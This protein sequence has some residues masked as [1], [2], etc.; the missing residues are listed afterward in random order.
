M[1]IREFVTR[2]YAGYDLWNS[3]SSEEYADKAKKELEDKGYKVKFLKTYD[4]LRRFTWYV[5][6]K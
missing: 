3:Y 1:S 4:A 6:Y 5:Y 2:G